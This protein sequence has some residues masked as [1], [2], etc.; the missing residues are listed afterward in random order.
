MRAPKV[1]TSWILVQSLDGPGLSTEPSD[2]FAVDPRNCPPR[3]PGSV[4][5]IY[6]PPIAPSPLGARSP[7]HLL[8][9][10]LQVSSPP[11]T[12]PGLYTSMAIS[13]GLLL[14]LFFLIN[15]GVA[16]P[17]QGRDAF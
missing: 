2:L 14:T 3:P 17:F 13:E 1:A 12:I 8:S 4:L 16:S 6:P 9:R 15:L 10:Y 11:P 5:Q 7:E